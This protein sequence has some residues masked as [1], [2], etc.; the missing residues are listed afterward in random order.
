MRKISTLACLRA[1]DY[2]GDDDNNVD[3]NGNGC[4]DDKCLVRFHR[5][6][7]RALS[8]P[9]KADKGLMRQCKAS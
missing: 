6:F 5:E 4:D 3:N 7:I 2:A 9:H 8:G 1:C